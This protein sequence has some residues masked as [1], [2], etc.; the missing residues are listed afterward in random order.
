MRFIPASFDDQ[1]FNIIKAVKERRP[2]WKPT[3]V[4]VLKR[5]IPGGVIPD[6]GSNILYEWGAENT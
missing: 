5:K 6:R 3:G 4:Y 2:W 1:L